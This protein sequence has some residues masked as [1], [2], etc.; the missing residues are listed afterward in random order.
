MCLMWCLAYRL[1][2][3]DGD[4]Q[5]RRNLARWSTE[6]HAREGHSCQPEP[7][8]SLTPYHSTLLYCAPVGCLAP[9][10]RLV[11]PFRPQQACPGRHPP[12][13]AV[14]LHLIPSSP[15]PPPS[16]IPSRLQNHSSRS[17][18]APQ[19][20]SAL[21]PLPASSASSPSQIPLCDPSPC[22]G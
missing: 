12:S 2:H 13:A 10:H 9:A 14:Q 17:P 1:C 4:C 19:R 18:V 11:A 20:W 21:P 22:T 16:R 5:A 3:S 8:P 15:S 7:H 6:Q